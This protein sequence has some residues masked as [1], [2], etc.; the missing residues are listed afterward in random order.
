MR[1]QLGIYRHARASATLHALSDRHKYLIR[2]LIFSHKCSILSSL[3]ALVCPAMP[4]MTV[5]C[6]L[7]PPSV[8]TYSSRSTVAASASIPSVRSRYS[9]ST[10]LFSSGALQKRGLVTMSSAVK[11]LVSFGEGVDRKLELIQCPVFQ[12]KIPCRC[13]WHFNPNCW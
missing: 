11:T 4:L 1:L 2:A 10:R 3:L 6:W 5:N 8:S 12:P 9:R 13:R 7:N